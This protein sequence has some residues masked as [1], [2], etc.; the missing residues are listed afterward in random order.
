MHA[1]PKG[2]PIEETP[3]E[4]KRHWWALGAR[5]QQD[6]GGCMMPVHTFLVLPVP[7]DTGGHDIAQMLAA[8]A[9][10]AWDQLLQAPDISMLRVAA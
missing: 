7:L 4:F 6:Q 8:L 2:I 3:F 9:N 1:E 10:S 5:D